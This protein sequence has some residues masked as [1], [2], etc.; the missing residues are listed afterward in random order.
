MVD[1]RGYVLIF[2]GKDHHL[3]DVR[4][5]AYEHRLVAE[6]MLG[7]RLLPEEIVHHRDENKGNNDQRNLQ[8]FVGDAIH[9][10]RP[11]LQSTGDP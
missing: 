4:G 9:R 7:R 3:A 6:T 2:V 10:A 8:V 5:Y 1:P 11:F